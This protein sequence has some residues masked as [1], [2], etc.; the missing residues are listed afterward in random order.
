MVAL[1]C[2]K[3]FAPDG[4]KSS[5]DFGTDST[6]NVGSK[7]HQDPNPHLPLRSRRPFSF[8][9][10]RKALDPSARGII[11]TS[12]TAPALRERAQRAGACACVM[13]DNLLKLGRLLLHEDKGGVL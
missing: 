11:V 1:R 10:R 12:Y 8:Y 2:Y 7:N 9:C 13:Q 6:A 4:A 3:Y 5:W